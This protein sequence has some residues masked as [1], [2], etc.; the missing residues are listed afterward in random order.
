MTRRCSRTVL[1]LVCAM[2]ACDGARDPVQVLDEPPRTEI[3]AG[4]WQ[5]MLIGEELPAPLVIR[6]LDGSGHPIADAPVTWTV[7]AGGGALRDASARTANDGTARAWWTLGPRTGIHAVSASVADYPPVLFGA[8]PI[9][10]APASLERVS[11]NAQTAVATQP[12]PDSLV[13]R[14]VDGRGYPVPDVAVA[15]SGDGYFPWRDT[16][17][18][19]RDGTAATRWLLG[20][21]FGGNEAIARVEGIDDVVFIATGT[22]E[23]ALLDLQTITVGDPHACALD[24]QGR[25][26]CWSNDDPVDA[27]PVPGDVRF[28]TLSAGQD[29]VCGIGTDDR[30]YCWGS[31]TAGSLG[32]GTTEPHS[33]PRP[34]ALEE[35]FVHLDV[36]RWTVC[37]LSTAGDVWCWGDH[38]ASAPLQL[39]TSS[40]EVAHVTV[41]Y[42]WIYLLEANG[43]VRSHLLSS[44]FD[45]AQSRDH[46]PFVT[47]DAAPGLVCGTTA[48]GDL[49]CGAEQQLPDFA[50][51]ATAGEQHRSRSGYYS[52]TVDAAGVT[53]CWGNEG[54]P[55]TVAVPSLRAIAVNDN[56]CGIAINDATYCW[57]GGYEALPSLVRR[58][59]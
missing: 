59:P 46:P 53:R 39:A 33:D 22:S 12:V 28:R 24:A 18:T 50:P 7:H 6:Y 48:T 20:A 10:G 19:N 43:R 9:A 5:S 57:S 15:W 30:A 31:N 45:M 34:I 58:A 2:L 13:V 23:G 47:L 27:Q 54:D 51:V 17:W 36:G 1:P 42:S 37:A 3:V 11:G 56:A 41:G 21:E 49:W 16:T 38:V 8:H 32:D 44:E 40:V 4:N 26:F 14:V 29:V 55:V 25:A 52:C 35:T